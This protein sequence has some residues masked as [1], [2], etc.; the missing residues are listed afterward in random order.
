MMPS[1]ERPL[2]LLSVSRRAPFRS[3][4]IWLERLGSLRMP[5]ISPVA[6]VESGIREP[7]RPASALP[8]DVGVQRALALPVDSG[9]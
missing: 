5:R 1:Q 2:P 4:R 3:T 7:F 9:A 6:R 8:I